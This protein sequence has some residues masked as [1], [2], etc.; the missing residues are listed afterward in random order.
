MKIKARNKIVLVEK[1]K[2][3]TEIGGIAI[4]GKAQKPTH[5]GVVLSV[6]KK[7]DDPDIKEGSIAIFN[8]SAGFEIDEDGVKYWVINQEDIIGGD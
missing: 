5:K 4:P 3:A 8:K 1:D 2:V 7:V 6:G